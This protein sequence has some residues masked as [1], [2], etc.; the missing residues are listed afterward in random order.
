MTQTPE[1]RFFTILQVQDLTSLSRSTIYAAMEG[2][3]A[4]PLFPK[5]IRIGRRVAWLEKEVRLWMA[6]RIAESVS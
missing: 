1:D 3:D 4:V 6:E 5:P 2:R